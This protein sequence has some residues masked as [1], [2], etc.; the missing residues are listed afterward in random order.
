M[1]CLSNQCCQKK[2]ENK[3]LC[4]GMNCIPLV[5]GVIAYFA[6]VN[7]L[8]LSARKIVLGATGA[9]L[10]GL[11]VLD[12]LYLCCKES[13]KTATKT[14]VDSQT[15]CIHSAQ[16]LPPSTLES[17][18]LQ[19]RRMDA[20]LDPNSN[21]AALNER[22]GCMRICSFNVFAPT[23]PN[24][25]PA[26]NMRKMRKKENGDYVLLEA[27][28]RKN[29][30]SKDSDVYNGFNLVIKPTGQAYLSNGML[31]M[32][33][34]KDFGLL[35]FQNSD[36]IVASRSSLKSFEGGFTTEVFEKI[37]FLTLEKSKGVWQFVEQNF[38]APQPPYC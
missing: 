11:C 18:D 8:S 2:V 35:T 29:E 16:S 17:K 14:Q 19:K 37:S 6:L 5:L 34:S 9:V 32:P 4:F 23:T 3:L 33:L 22:N 25:R 36:Y 7:Q 30:N 31:E 13:G 1:Y 24:Y 26:I 12:L 27:S 10:G 28:A 20:Y 38:Y 15:K 21:P